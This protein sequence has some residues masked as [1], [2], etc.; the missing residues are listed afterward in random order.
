[1]SSFPLPLTKL[2]KYTIIYILI[3]TNLISMLNLSEDPKQPDEDSSQPRWDRIPETRIVEIAPDP[4][5]PALPPAIEQ[6]IINDILNGT[7]DVFKLPTIKK[8]DAGTCLN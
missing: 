1:M 8:P 4:A 3:I 6:D 5:G 2:N 7:H